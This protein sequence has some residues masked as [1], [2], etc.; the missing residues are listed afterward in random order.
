MQ[1]SVVNFEVKNI[2]FFFFSSEPTKSVQVKKSDNRMIIA[3]F[4][5]GGLLVLAL[6]ILCTLCIL[7]KIHKEKKSHTLPLKDIKPINIK[8]AE[9]N[10]RPIRVRGFSSGGSGGSFMPLLKPGSI[11]SAS[12]TTSGY[13]GEMD[14][15]YHGPDQSSNPAGIDLLKVNYRN[16]RIRRRSSVFIVDFEHIP[17]LV[18]L[19]LTL[20][21]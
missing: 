3:S 20:N 16:T 13:G 8:S 12:D 11:K 6:I 5:I 10:Y 15:K 4:V 7:L 21:M 18:F 17:H 14:G 1:K 19:F 9:G 2:C